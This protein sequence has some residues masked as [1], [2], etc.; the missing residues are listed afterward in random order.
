MPHPNRFRLVAT[1]IAVTGIMIGAVLSGSG[2][3]DAAP[4]VGVA[5]HHHGSAVGHHHGP[6]IGGPSGDHSQALARYM[7]PTKADSGPTPGIACD[8]GSR[9]EKV[10][11]KVPKADYDSGRAAKGYFCNARQIS[12]FLSSGGYR[13]ER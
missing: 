9:P 5:A 4:K 11:G 12:H 2:G 8:K 7:G 13:V 1:A 10:Q 6:A 3:P